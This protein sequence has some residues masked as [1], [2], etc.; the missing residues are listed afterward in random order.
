MVVGSIAFYNNRRLVRTGR[1]A[2]AE[3]VDVEVVVR[4]NE[5]PGEVSENRTYYPVVRFSTA[6]GLEVRARTRSGGVPAPAHTGDQV[7]VIY[8]PRSPQNVA[9]DTRA[10]RGTL[11]SGLVVIVGLG[12]IIFQLVG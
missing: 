11:L 10:G 2:R 5:Y 1:R 12:A 8:D 6:D 3:V 4:R 7:R 9:L